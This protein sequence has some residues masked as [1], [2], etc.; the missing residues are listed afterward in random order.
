MTTMAPSCTPPSFHPTSR[1]A[2]DL[3]S[4]IRRLL[5]S[6]SLSE[7]LIRC[8]PPWRRFELLRPPRRSRAVENIPWTWLSL[9]S[10]LLRRGTKGENLANFIVWAVSVAEVHGCPASDFLVQLQ[11]F[12]QVSYENVRCEYERFVTL[13]SWCIRRSGLFDTFD[14]MNWWIYSTDLAG[15]YIRPNR[16]LGDFRQAAWHLV[17][18]AI[19]CVSIMGRFD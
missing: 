15:Q 4:M 5:V 13:I 1:F 14:R 7:T 19:S 9:A 18:G 3:I 11:T 10:T 12:C 6:W 17:Y 8:R 16:L 2:P